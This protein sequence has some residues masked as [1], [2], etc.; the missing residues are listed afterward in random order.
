MSVLVWY[1]G[2]SFSSIEQIA[3]ELLPQKENSA[4]DTPDYVLT[5][6][7]LK[8]KHSSPTLNPKFLQKAAIIAPRN[9]VAIGQE[10]FKLNKN[11][12]GK[13]H[14]VKTKSFLILAFPT[15]L[16]SQTSSSSVG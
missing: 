12:A 7:S 13:V 5:K 11:I 6:Q 4:S 8:N 1:K 16:E 9:T 14:S 15:D 3:C 10:S 2:N